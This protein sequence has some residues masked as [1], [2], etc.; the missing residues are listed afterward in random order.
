MKI[1]IVKGTVVSTQ[2]DPRLV[3][4]KLLIVRRVD[5]GKN[6]IGEDEV[7]VDTLG[8]GEGEV[9][10]LCG[11]SSARMLMSEA[12]SPVD[13]AVIGIIDTLEKS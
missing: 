2:K 1:G 12:S 4:S 10:L 3:G 6:V 13:L 9:V 11:G 5:A 8:A 7:A